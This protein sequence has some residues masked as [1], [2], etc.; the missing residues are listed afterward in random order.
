MVPILERG[1]APEEAVGNLQAA[2]PQSFQALEEF[3]TQSRRATKKVPMLGTFSAFAI[4]T[5]FAKYFQM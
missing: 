5:G 1:K 2:K 4:L 3:L